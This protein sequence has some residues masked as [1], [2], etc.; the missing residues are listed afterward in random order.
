[1]QTDHLVSYSDAAEV[2][3]IVLALLITSSASVAVVSAAGRGATLCAVV[4]STAKQVRWCCIVE[5]AELRDC[6]RLASE[7]EVIHAICFGSRGPFVTVVRC[8]LH[9]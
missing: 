1:M 6:V 3:C 4:I 2:S 7:A 9:C 5:L 8:M